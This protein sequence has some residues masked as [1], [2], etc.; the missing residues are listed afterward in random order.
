MRFFSQLLYLT[1]HVHQPAIDPASACHHAVTGE[2]YE[3]QQMFKTSKNQSRRL[4]TGSNN[5]PSP[6]SC[7]GPCQNR[8]SGAPQTC[9]SPRR[10]PGPAE[11]PLAPW[12]SAYPEEHCDTPQIIMFL[13]THPWRNTRKKRALLLDHTTFYSLAKFLPTGAESTGAFI[14][15]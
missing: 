7:P 4:K 9:P 6:C 1:E 5:R 11:A 13:N 8:S 2:L 12:L 15:M 14:K 3:R 10:S